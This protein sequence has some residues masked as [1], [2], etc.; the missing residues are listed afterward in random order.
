MVGTQGQAVRRAVGFARRVFAGRRQAARLDR[1]PGPSGG[2]VDAG[3]S[4]SPGGNT[5][6]VRVPPR[7]PQNQALKS[8][9]NEAV[10]LVLPF[11]K[12]YTTSHTKCRGHVPWRN[13][14]FWAAKFTST[15]G[16]KARFGSVRPISRARTAG[17]QR[18]KPVC[19]PLASSAS[20][21]VAV[22]SGSR[23]DDLAN[24]HDGRTQMIFQ[25]RNILLGRG[26]CVASSRLRISLAT[27]SALSRSMPASTRRL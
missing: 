10:G 11:H 18:R 9:L 3:D 24:P 19:P 4:K 16:Q 14:R 22:T 2:M 8:K 21:G 7:V 20:T 17:Y 25:V 5:L 1:G 23:S 15:N 26:G 6:W 13:T 27:G 12:R